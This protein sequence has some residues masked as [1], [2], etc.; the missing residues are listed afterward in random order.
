MMP[1]EGTALVVI[2]GLS[3]AMAAM[4]LDE[5]STNDFLAWKARV[6]APIQRALPDACILVIDHPGHGDLDRPRGASGKT[7]AVDLSLELKTS[8]QWAYL[9]HRKDRHGVTGTRRGAK[10]AEVR[11]HFDPDETV[12]V[13]LRTVDAPR[14]PEG[15]WLP[16]GYMAKVSALMEHGDEL[17]GNQIEEQASGNRE[18]VRTAYKAL[19]RYGFLDAKPGP[20]RG[21]F[22][23][24]VK[25]YREGDDFSQ[26]DR[27]KSQVERP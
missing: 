7:Q 14:G 3:H 6:V 8:G 21:M 5:N 25:P 20:R 15:E 27:A 22:Y 17:S 19:A 12:T 2:N 4:D 11:L 9:Y 24:S 18:H 16:T 23:R 13:E 26:S 10:V 1:P